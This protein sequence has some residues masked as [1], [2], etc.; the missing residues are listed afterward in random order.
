MC[1]FRKPA[2]KQVFSVRPTAVFALLLKFAVKIKKKKKRKRKEKK[3]YN[4][5]K[6]NVKYNKGHVW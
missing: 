4:G 2:G 6:D 3:S 1:D 5:C